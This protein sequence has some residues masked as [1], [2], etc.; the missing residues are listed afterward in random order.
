MAD[1][2]QKYC[3]QCHRCQIAKKPVIGVH[4][5]QGHLL[6]TAPLEI[7]AM[8]FTK[9]EPASDGRE[10]VL[11]LTDV[12]TKWTMAIPTRDQSAMSVTRVLIREWIPH[13]G[14]P[15]RL[16]SDQGKCFEAEVIK[17]LC[18]HYGVAKSRTSPY[19]PGGNGICE[20]FNRSLHNLLR[21]LSEQQKHRWPEF[22]SELIFWY[23]STPHS[24]TGQCPYFLLFGREPRL[25]IDVYL[26]RTPAEAGYTSAGDY[27]ARHL[28]RLGEIHQLAGERTKRAA[29]QRETPMPRGATQLKAGDLV[30]AKRHLPGRVKIQDVWG[31]KVYVV[32]ST[33]PEQGGPF[34]IRPRDEDGVPRRVTGSKIRLYVAPVDLPLLFHVQI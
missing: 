14:V 5:T 9:L 31:E 30:L 10:D 15:R 23:N 8:D 34:V 33:P 6:A 4:Q 22:V 7:V 13:Y 12:F 18:E 17:C 11:V 2:V 26:G 25:P 1:D 19:N 20:R 21:V 27:L 29:Q 32:V 3:N 28:R 24:T 16:H